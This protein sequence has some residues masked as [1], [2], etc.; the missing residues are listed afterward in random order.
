MI[1]VQKNELECTKDMQEFGSLLDDLIFECYGDLP[2]PETRQNVE[3]FVVQAIRRAFYMGRDGIESPVKPGKPD[4]APR[5]EK[6][7]DRRD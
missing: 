3:R 5:E 2:T 1:L 4:G 7:T 6:G